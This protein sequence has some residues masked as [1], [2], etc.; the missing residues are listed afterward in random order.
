MFD[1]TDW[2]IPFFVVFIIIQIILIV[3]RCCFIKRR[4]AAYERIT[5]ST[6]PAGTSTE[7]SPALQYVQIP[8][9][10]PQYS[11]NTSYQYAPV[12]VAP[13]YSAAKPKEEEPPPPYVP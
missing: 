11:P 3:C 7:E 5:A 8:G 1:D 2:W 12:P 10:P 9:Q 13:P 6:V 4:Q